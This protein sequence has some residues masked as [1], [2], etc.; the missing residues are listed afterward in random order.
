MYSMRLSDKG[1]WYCSL[2]E[3]SICSFLYNIRSWLW[4]IIVLLLI[5]KYGKLYIIVLI[6]VYGRNQSSLFT[7]IKFIE[8]YFT[9]ISFTLKVNL[10]VITVRSMY[11]ILIK[12]VSFIFN[13]LIRH[14]KVIEILLWKWRTVT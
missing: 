13:I 10:F 4:N 11:N 7:P 2:V 14:F 12:R 5:L 9:A 6:N 8:K 3:S 1:T